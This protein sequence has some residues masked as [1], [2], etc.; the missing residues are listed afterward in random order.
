MHGI[1]KRCMALTACMHLCVTVFS[2]ACRAVDDPRGSRSV[3]G[4]ERRVRLNGV[5]RE[6][7]ALQRVLLGVGPEA[8]LDESLAEINNSLKLKSLAVT[9]SV[10]NQPAQPPPQRESGP[11]RPHLREGREDTEHEMPQERAASSASLQAHAELR[12]QAAL[13][14]PRSA[15]SRQAA[16]GDCN[17]V[18]GEPP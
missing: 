4:L 10:E 13:R 7:E 1:G 16:L 12:E 5:L 14:Q 15:G 6:L 3:R 17:V 8:L 2:R 18:A 9:R 11:P